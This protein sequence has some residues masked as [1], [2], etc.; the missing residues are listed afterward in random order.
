MSGSNKKIKG[1]GFH[2][3][4][5]KVRDLKKSIRFY[6]EGL[7]FVERFSWGQDPKRTVL[8][9]TGDGNY[10]EISQGDPD[11]VY[12]DG[13]F[14]HLALR[15]DDC[16]AALEVA[17]AAGAEVTTETRDVTISSEPPL[18][19]RIAF[20]KGPDEELIELFQD[21]QT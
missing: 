19:L 15:V 13:V 7:G 3:V 16:D 5:M 12:G 2:H 6:S 8:M 21:D 4:S 11:Q 18:Q 10:F 1:C 14:R 9:D 17:R 20:F